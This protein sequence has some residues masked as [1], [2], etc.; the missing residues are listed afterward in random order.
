M[1]WILLE[2]LDRRT[3]TTPGTNVALRASR[4]GERVVPRG[5]AAS[6]PG[7]AVQMGE[8]YMNERTTRGAA[9]KER[10]VN[11]VGR[12]GQ[13]RSLR[14][15]RFRL[16]APDKVLV[17][18]LSILLV[19]AG[20]VALGAQDGGTPLARRAAA[21]TAPSRLAVEN[22]ASADHAAADPI[23]DSPL[24]ASSKR[25]AVAPSPRE[26]LEDA[27]A[28]VLSGVVVDASGGPIGGALI[29]VRRFFATE[30]IATGSSDSTGRFRLAAPLGAFEIS[31]Q[32]EAYSRAALQLDTPAENL[33]LVLAPEA[34]IDGRVVERTT[35]KAVGNV[36]VRAANRN[37]IRAPE[38]SAITG[39]DGSFRILNLAGGGYDVQAIDARF[40]SDVRWV[41]VDVGQAS[42][43]IE[44]LVDHAVTLTASIHAAG[45]PC[46]TGWIQLSGPVAATAN[47]GSDG[48]ARLEGLLP[49]RYSLLAQ[50]DGAIPLHETL[51]LNDEPLERALELERGLELRGSVLSTA[52]SGL[53]GVAVLVHPVPGKDMPQAFG[54]ATHQCVTDPSGAFACSGFTPGSYDCEAQAHGK[55][56]SDTLRVTL[57]AAEP[58]VIVLTASGLASIRATLQ[59]GA[60]GLGR[61]AVFARRGQELP[62]QAVRESDE[63][64]FDNLELGSY[65]VYV[66]IGIEE[67]AK[68]RR[69]ELTQAGQVVDV[70]LDLPAPLAISGRVLD[71][72]RQPVP[73]TWVHA[74]TAEPM[75]AE[76]W[77]DAVLTDELG[78]FTV[79]DLSPGHYEL[80]ATHSS[81][82]GSAQTEAGAQGVVVLL[83]GQAALAGT[84]TAMTGE[85]VT[86]GFTLEYG[87]PGAGS[88]QLVLTTGARWAIPSLPPGEYQLVASAK[89]GSAATTV[90]LRAGARLDVPLMLSP[91]AVGSGPTAPEAEAP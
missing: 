64:V 83:E 39:A 61:S 57:D 25:G 84:V 65:R 49:G 88:E 72:R 48:V 69:V 1:R 62:V 70:S 59:S 47:S 11:D 63:F 79:A 76:V 22:A 78:A 23:H 3:S 68:A 24:A 41:T 55:K 15:S 6:K 77:D 80:R 44:L 86:N 33:R 31:A 74:T 4:E 9:E 46:A 13:A 75:R 37:G 45:A 40:R 10:A 81:G 71:A 87:R 16:F 7:L 53:S 21:S 27:N 50:C 54:P 8:G 30:P 29:L 17:A 12:Y 35:G 32:A 28:S 2:G 38:A 36:T 56:I 20:I 34:R 60:R 43:A 85:P 89:Q 5:Q 42:D 66:G 52:G 18:I 26:P 19:L 14:T 73:D 90:T 58:T 67:P 51:E 91:D 82:E